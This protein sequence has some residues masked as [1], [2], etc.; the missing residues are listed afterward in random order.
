MRTKNMQTVYDFFFSNDP[1]SAANPPTS[2]P[3]KA[4]TKKSNDL[5]GSV[6]MRATFS[7]NDV[8]ADESIS[9]AFAN[10]KMAIPKKPARKLAFERTTI[11]AARA[12]NAMLHHGRNN[13]NKKASMIMVMT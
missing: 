3:S 10:H 5:F 2:P 9:H 4:I 11:P 12:A 13:S 6:K 8:E 7:T 1:V